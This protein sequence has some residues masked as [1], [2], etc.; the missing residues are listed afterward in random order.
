L[1]LTKA[2]IAG[3]PLPA[4]RDTADLIY[5]DEAMPGFGLRLRGGRRSWIVQYRTKGKQRRL[6][7]GSA[8]VLDP[9]R[10]R[11]AAKE[12]LA[13]IALGGDPQRDKVEDRRRGAVTLGSLV[14][15]YLGFR[16]PV[17]RANTMRML[18]FYLQRTW[19]SLHPLPIHEITRRDVAARLT[20]IIAESGQVSAGRAHAA[21][22]SF[23]G[24]AVREG[25]VEANPVL[26]TNRPLEPP[27]RERVLSNGEIAEAWAAL[28]ACNSPTY[29]KIVR[30]LLLTACRRAEIGGLRWSEFDTENGV[31][32]LP[33]ERTKNKEPHAIPLPSMALD[34]LADIERRPGRDLIFGTGKGGF[35][36][37][38]EAKD[39]L[40]NCIT[41]ARRAAGNVE[42]MPG[43]RLHDL[44]RTVATVMADRLGVLPHVIEAVLNHVSG[45]K[46]GVA[47]TYN[48]ALYEREVRTALT[49]WADYIR[50]IV[51]G[52]AHKVVPMRTA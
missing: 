12:H 15:T 23:F 16:E 28:D 21:L 18:R 14:E 7:L 29:A 51:D 19:L 31:I 48:R 1:K 37:W 36:G 40:D 3:L 35:Q 25:F 30:L 10:A 20:K 34:I 44:R 11:A 47:G 41:E 4:D 49:L 13:K 26:N 32:K 43:W 52:S 33:R 46:A 22:S 17:L 9:D 6:T 8:Q 38:T 5:F 45:H 2:T 24:W 27:A 42:P 39:A 50:A